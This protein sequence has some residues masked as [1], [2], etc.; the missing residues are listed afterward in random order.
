MDFSSFLLSL[1][2][3]RRLL[4]REWDLLRLGL[5]DLL[6]LL[7]CDLR[8]DLLLECLCL[9][10]DLDLLRRDREWERECLRLSSFLLPGSM[11]ADISDWASRT[12]FIASSIS[13][14]EASAFMPDVKLSPIAKGFNFGSI[15]CISLNRSADR[16]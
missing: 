13:L 3:L 10:R 6:L 1:E 7:E 2:R 8:R 14:L 16:A 9:E 4:S 15:D 12:L 11:A 5:L